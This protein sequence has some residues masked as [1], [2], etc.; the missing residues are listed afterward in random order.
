MNTLLRFDRPAGYDFTRMAELLCNDICLKLPAFSHV[1]MPR[2]VVGFAQARND[3][4]FGLYASL[5]PLRFE[6]GANQV[7]RRGRIWTLPRYLNEEGTEFLY[8]INFYQPRYQNLPRREKLT[9]AVHELW[10]ISPEF[11]GDLRRFPGR[12]YAHGSR[13]SNYDAKVERLTDEYLHIGVHPE[14]EDLLECD[15][16]G[17]SQKYGRIHG[18]KVAAPKMVPVSAK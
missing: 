11:D 16:E 5:T 4:N 18:R 12:C 2:V 8:I 17:L 3:S 10:H 14:V 1:E 7:E 6:D 13:Q 9:T 15:F